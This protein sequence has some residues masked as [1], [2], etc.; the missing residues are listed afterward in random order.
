MD[1]VFDQ[2]L[3]DWDTRLVTD[4]SS[5]FA[6]ST[7]NQDVSNWNVSLMM[8]MTKMFELTHLFNQDLSCWHVT[9]VL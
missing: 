8:N 6:K 1:A 9:K 3:L 4:M 2:P 7:F 5:V